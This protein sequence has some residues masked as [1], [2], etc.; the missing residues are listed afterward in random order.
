[1][2]KHQIKVLATHEARSRRVYLD[3]KG[4]PDAEMEYQKWMAICSLIAGVQNL[5]TDDE[6]R[7]YK[8]FYGAEFA[9]D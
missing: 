1:M 9:C 8:A 3:A 5:M 2:N 6:I 7:L 4:T